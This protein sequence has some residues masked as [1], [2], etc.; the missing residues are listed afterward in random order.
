MQADSG[1][2]KKKDGIGFL[3]DLTPLLKLEWL[4][5]KNLAAKSW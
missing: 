1:D 4:N 3:S 5:Y 2:L